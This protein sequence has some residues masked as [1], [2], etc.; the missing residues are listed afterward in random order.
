[1]K[2]HSESLPNLGDI[3]RASRKEKKLTLEKLSI[4]SGISKSMLSQIERGTVSPTFSVV[5]NLTQCLGID[6]SVLGESATTDNLINHIPAYSTPIKGSEDE[7]CTLRML[8]PLRTVLPVEWYELIA[9]AG[10]VLDSVA[11]AT[12][13]YEHLSCLSGVLQVQAGELTSIANAGDTL[14]YRAD[15]PHSIHNI[16]DGPATALLVVGLPTQYNTRHL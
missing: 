11:H 6:L 14:R 4:L 10:G 7:R 8:N 12:G 3:V 9:E 2:K 13:T 1:M 15:Q 16:G 5:W